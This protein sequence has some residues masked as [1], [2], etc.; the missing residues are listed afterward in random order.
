MKVKTIWSENP[1]AFD[2]KVNAWLEEGWVLAKRD[3]LP[4]PANLDDSVFYAEMVLHDPA[5]E[6]ADAMDHVWAIRDVCASIGIAD[7]NENKCPLAC[8]CNRVQSDS[9]GGWISPEEWR[10]PGKEDQA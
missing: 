1:G 8:W 4:G 2:E 9:T 7:C 3:I 5:P 6:T 10:L